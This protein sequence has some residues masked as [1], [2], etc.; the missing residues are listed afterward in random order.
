MISIVLFS[1]IVRGIIPLHVSAKVFGG[2]V[3]KCNVWEGRLTSEW[4][5]DVWELPSGS[6]IW[7]LGSVE[8][9]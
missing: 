4:E 8:R 2:Y 6:C 9:A 1:R 5:D 7:S 3:D